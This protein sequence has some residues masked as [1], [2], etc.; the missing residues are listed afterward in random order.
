MPAPVLETVCEAIRTPG[1]SP[2]VGDRRPKS[3]VG[4]FQSPEHEGDGLPPGA[5]RLN[6]HPVVNSGFLYLGARP[7][8][9]AKRCG[10][11][12]RGR[13]ETLRLEI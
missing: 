12:W 5:S 10:Q 13:N 9:Y 4:T 11:V 1:V 3:L 8:R 2:E 6:S 7:H